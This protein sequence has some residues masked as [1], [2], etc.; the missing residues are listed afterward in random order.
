MVEVILALPGVLLAQAIEVAD[1]E[2]MTLA[3]F[4]AQVVELALEVDGEEAEE[5]E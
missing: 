3:E 2:G 1:E 5:A 4:V